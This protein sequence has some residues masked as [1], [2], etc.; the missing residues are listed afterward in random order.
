MVTAMERDD[1]GSPR[2]RAYRP[3][4][5]A[6]PMPDPDRGDWTAWE[7]LLGDRNHATGTGP[8][9]SLFIDPIPPGGADLFG[10][11]SSSLIALPAIHQPERR[12]VFR[13]TSGPPE[14]W[15]WEEVSLP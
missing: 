6:A 4:F 3:R 7:Q 10:T 12:P 14:F 15:R 5:L 1:P 13:F 9:E 2:I 8:S 11:S